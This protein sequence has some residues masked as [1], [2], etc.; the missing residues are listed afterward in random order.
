MLSGQQLLLPKSQ[1]RLVAGLRRVQMDESFD[2]L[3]YSSP[4]AKTI[5][6]NFVVVRS[7]NDTGHSQQHFDSSRL[8]YGEVLKSCRQINRATTAERS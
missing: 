7:G 4:V 6:G 5:S 8:Y 1:I 3:Q 2:L